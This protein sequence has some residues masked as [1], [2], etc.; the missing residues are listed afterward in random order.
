MPG[1]FVTSIIYSHLP[2]KWMFVRA[3]RGS[4]H[5]TANTFKHWAVWLACTGGCVLFS[6]IVA[7]AIPVFGGLIGLIG[8]FFGT[9]LCMQVRL[10]LFLRTQSSLLR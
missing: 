6:Y 4:E 3:L 9:I 1:L 8:A 5:L 7:S 2:A 10:H